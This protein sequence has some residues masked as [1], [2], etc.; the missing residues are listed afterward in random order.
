MTNDPMPLQPVTESIRI[1]AEPKQVWDAIM[2]PDADETWR[3]AHFRTD[4]QIG[5]PIEIEA[6]IGAKRYH[7]K[8]H[9]LRVQPPMLLEF[10]YWSQVSGLPDV[11]QCYATVTMTLAAD[12]GETVLT[13]AQQ[14]PP[15]PIRRGN[16][17]EIGADSGARHVAFYWRMALPR[18]KQAVEQRHCAR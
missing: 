14:V 11:P 8:G 3:N 16:G 6:E 15:S 5:A 10:S 12:G 18:L 13:V 4:W 2:A 9:V 7:D 1:A 17:W